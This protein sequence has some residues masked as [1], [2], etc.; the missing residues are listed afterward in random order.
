[1][2]CPDCGIDLETTSTP[3]GVL[4]AC[5]RCAGLW[6]DKD[7]SG[8][9]LR[10]QLSESTVNLIRRINAEPEREPG[11]YRD[12]ARTGSVDSNRCCPVCRETLDAKRLHGGDVAVDVCARHGTWFG[13]RKLWRLT[14]S[15]RIDRMLE[16]A[17]F[18]TF[19]DQVGSH[20]RG[21]W[22]PMLKWLANTAWPRV[23]QALSGG[24]AQGGLSDAQA[25]A[26]S[27]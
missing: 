22:P 8:R 15:L 26:S 5:S 14:Q 24:R 9:A 13:R 12:A 19:D 10:E 25:P 17:G 7:A 6:L 4:C 18:G 11:G 3:D 21:Q 1:M 20:G 27:R 23:A 16:D 2:K